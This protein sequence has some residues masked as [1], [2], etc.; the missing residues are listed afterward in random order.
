MLG[1]CGAMPAAAQ[2]SGS[3]DPDHPNRFDRSLVLSGGGARGA[4]EAGII[5]Y[6]RQS[7]RIEDGQ[8]LSPYGFVC[9]T[10]IGALNAYM[11]ATGQYTK[12]RELWYTISSLRAV[13]LK[14]QYA[15]ITNH[16]AGVG[17]RLGQAV[18]LGFG[19]TS[20]V[21]GVIDGAHLREFL[22]QHMD[23]GQPV[24]TPCTWTVTNLSRHAPEY[25]YITPQN[26]SAELIDRARAVARSAIGPRAVLRP[27]T[28]DLLIDSLQASAAL[29]VAFDPV[30]LPAFDG[31]GVQQYC[32]GGVTE[33]TPIGIARATARNV[34]VVMLDPPIES[35]EA[36]KNAVEI[37]LASF[38][39]LQRVLLESNVRSA[40]FE[41]LCKRAFM[42]MR[43]TPDIRRIS[44]LLFASDFYLI[45]PQNVLP[46]SVAG[47]DDPDAIYNTYKIGFED[48]KNG[49]IKFDFEQAQHQS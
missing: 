21:T 47:F 9:G 43:L 15:K 16:D 23:P 38:G 8:P 46:V 25:F 6:V 11:V 19:L 33:N 28:P 3:F 5:D 32:D 1:A 18:S 40:Y 12:L 44:A 4:Y 24:L 7:L 22:S 20:H 34:D 41:S 39:T 42:R 2:E 27:A 13:R 36:Y 14:K 30:E 17:T 29:P 49:F 37:G 10:S 35:E 48:A 26:M 45:R 31:S